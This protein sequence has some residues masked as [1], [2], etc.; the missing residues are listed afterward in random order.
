[1]FIN[2]L[3]TLFIIGC[4]QINSFNKPNICGEL[5][6]RDV[7]LA[8]SDSSNYFNDPGYSNQWYIKKIELDKA[9]KVY[10]PNKKVKVAVFD[11]QFYLNDDIEEF[12][13]KNKSISYIGSIGS[14]FFKNNTTNPYIKHGS[15]V[16]SIICAKQNN[17]FGISGI[18]NNIELYCYSVIDQTGRFPMAGVKQDHSSLI[19]AIEHCKTNGIDIINMS[20]HFQT[21]DKEVENAIS[22]FNGLVVCSS[23]NDGVNIDGT[24]NKSYP[25]NYDLD[26]ILSVGATDISRDI[27]EHSN[28]NSKDVDIFAPGVNITSLSLNELKKDSGTSFSTPIVTGL[29]AMYLSMNP[30]AK[31][32]EIK[33]RILNSPSVIS[34]NLSKYCKSGGIV[35][36]LNIIHDHNY[37]YTYLSSLK[38]K[39]ICTC[40]DNEIE[41]GHTVAGGSFSGGKRYA[42]CLRC[43]GLAEMGFTE[44]TININNTGN[45]YFEYI[46][47]LYYINETQYID[48]ILNIS[49]KDYISGSY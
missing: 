7:I 10:K 35:N 34:S 4:T 15:F 25:S 30:N 46:D 16:S 47:G 19:K 11:S 22:N 42:N 9:W 43:G 18:L 1:M 44:E 38:H 8:S 3:L 32:A 13:N 45:Y 24:T 5:N 14:P 33:D 41:E 21:Y 40:L 23:G 39:Y 20:L 12:I 26:N 49:Y 17:N 27:W 37:S 36:A 6:Y 28:Y 48:D 29:A 31:P 2:N